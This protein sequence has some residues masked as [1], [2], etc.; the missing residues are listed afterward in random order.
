MFEWPARQTLDYADVVDAVAAVVAS[1]KGMF[2]A[3]ARERES[4]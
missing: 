1:A 2:F 4:Y 3:V